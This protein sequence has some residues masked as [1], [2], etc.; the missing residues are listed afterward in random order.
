[1]NIT[2]FLGA[3]LGDDQMYLME[4]KALGQ[5]IGKKGHRL[6]Y[7]GGRIGLMGA[8]A[9]AVLEN[10]GEVTGVVPEFFL[11][12]GTEHKGLTE[13]IKTATI[14]ERREK[15]IELGANRIGTSSGTKL[16]AKGE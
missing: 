10:G 8:L 9:D 13:M 3:N 14:S 6:I 12:R 5:W 1:M 11:N 16:I 4:V 15:M 2:V 7:G